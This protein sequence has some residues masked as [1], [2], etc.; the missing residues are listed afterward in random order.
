MTT[1]EML[2]WDDKIAQNSDGGSV[3]QSAEVAEAKRLGGWESL[4]LHCEDVVI[5]VLQKPV[6]GLGKLW[7]IPK[8]PGITELSQLKQLLPSLQQQAKKAGVFVV[9][10]EPELIKLPD[11][12]HEITKLGFIP[13]R[14][15]QPNSSTVLIDLH[16]SEHEILASF[17]QKGRHAINRA[18]RDGVAAKAVPF[19]DENAK[20]MYDL[21]VQTARGRFEQSIRPYAYYHQFWHNFYATGR[22]SLF[23][24]Y[25]EGRVVSAA[26]AM[27]LGCKSTY[28]DGASVRDKQVYGAS[29]L[30]QWEIIKWAK[31]RGCIQHD[32]CGAPPSDRADDPS[33]PHHGIGRFK[34]S[35][36]KH[37]TDYVGAYDLPL[38][39]PHY[40]LWTTI[41]ER[42]TLRAYAKRHKQS[43]Y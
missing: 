38:M 37:I 28:K 23:F 41:G 33:H 17:N 4:Y 14:P 24:A 35:F 31:A 32:L 22:G 39:P 8:G 18:A 16:P 13:A 36:N 40:K 20:I 19:T 34:T 3:F 5:T 25:S 11:I 21:L 29:H 42:L 2:A 27:Y 26:F 15:I 7:Y 6:L 1:E 10:I 9:K 30:L 43:W 12:A